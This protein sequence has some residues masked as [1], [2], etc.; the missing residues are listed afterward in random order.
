[1]PSVRQR[2]CAPRTR[3]DTFCRLSL[4]LAHCDA[5]RAAGSGLVCQ[6][7]LAAA[8]LIIAVAEAAQGG[9][10]RA[11]EQGDTG[12]QPAANVRKLHDAEGGV[13]AWAALGSIMRQQQSMV[14]VD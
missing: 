8:K 4:H 14:H 9:A 10:G 5:G 3:A 7:E 11:R 1:M 13:P 6:A 12:P 2:C